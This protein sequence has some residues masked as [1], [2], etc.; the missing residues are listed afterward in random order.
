MGQ[1]RF[2]LTIYRTK[3]SLSDNLTFD[4]SWRRNDLKFPNKLKI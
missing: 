1:V 4:N 3:V 2:A